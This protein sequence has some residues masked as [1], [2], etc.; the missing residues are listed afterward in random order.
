MT[1][2]IVIEDASKIR[3]PMSNLGLDFIVA[4]LAIYQPLAIGSSSCHESHSGTKAQCHNATERT[5]RVSKESGIARV[6]KIN[7]QAPPRNQGIEG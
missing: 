4:R 2:S 7:N 5:S 3:T 1:E 6:I